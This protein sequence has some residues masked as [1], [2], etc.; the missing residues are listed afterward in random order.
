MKELRDAVGSRGYPDNQSS[1]SNSSCSH[2]GDSPPSDNSTGSASDAGRARVYNLAQHNVQA[3]QHKQVSVAEARHGAALAEQREVWRS[4]V[5]QVRQAEAQVSADEHSCQKV[6]AEREVPWARPHRIPRINRRSTMTGL[7]EQDRLRRNNS[8]KMRL[9]LC[10]AQEAAAASAASSLDR[11]EG[12]QAAHM[13]LDAIAGQ[14]NVV[15]ARES[16]AYQ[17]LAPFPISA[18]HSDRDHTS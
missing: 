9:D 12:C 7:Q 4:E 2:V 18:P 16:A 3:I 17:H 13:S 14:S 6:S 5:T 15:A 1:S 8:S 11:R 10:S